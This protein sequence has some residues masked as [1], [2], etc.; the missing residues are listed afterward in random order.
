MPFLDS[1][2]R[3]QLFR[4]LSQFL[5]L[6]LIG[7]KVLHFKHYSD[8]SKFPFLYRHRLEGTVREH[9]ALLLTERQQNEAANAALAE[10]QARNEAL[11]SKLEDAVKQND[12]LHEAAQRL[13]FLFQKVMWPTLQIIASSIIPNL[14]IYNVIAIF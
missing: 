8:N 9:E 12:L 14:H 10:S 3:F 13:V 11:V 1:L 6:I 4:K 5:N 7:D 2:H